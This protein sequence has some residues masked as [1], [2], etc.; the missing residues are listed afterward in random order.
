LTK[1]L[2]Q[3]ALPDLVDLA[4]DLNVQ[5]RRA[6]AQSLVEVDYLTSGPAVTH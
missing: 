6:V 3:E 2:G 4:E 5:V 1:L